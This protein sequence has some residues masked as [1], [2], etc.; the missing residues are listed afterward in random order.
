MRRESLASSQRSL[1]D[2]LSPEKQS[3]RA[4]RPPFDVMQAHFALAQLHAYDGR[5][6]RALAQYQQAYET[7]RAGVPAATLRM[8]EALGVAHLH[9]AGMDNGTHR[10]PGDICLFPLRPGQSYA[11]TARLG[12]RHRALPN[13]S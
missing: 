10:A 4:S 11:K 2:F 12:T 5:M 9:K 3:A 6:D 1:D 7:A 13:V 8:E